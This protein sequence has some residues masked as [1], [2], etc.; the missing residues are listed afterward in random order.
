VCVWHYVQGPWGD[1]AGVCVGK[2]DRVLGVIFHLQVDPR[3][4]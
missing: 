3:L 2:D 1:T 4:V